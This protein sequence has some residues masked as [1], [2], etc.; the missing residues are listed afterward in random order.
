MAD[1]ALHLLL[2]IGGGYKSIDTEDQPE[3][4]AVNLRM[5][6]AHSEPDP[7][8]PIAAT[9]SVVEEEQSFDRTAYTVSGAWRLEGGV[10]DFD[11]VSYLEDQ[12]INYINDWCNCVSLSAYAQVHYAKLFAV[13]V[14]GK[15]L[16]PDGFGQGSPA[17]LTYKTGSQP[18]GNGSSNVLPP[19]IA[20]VASHRTRQTG[21]G[22]QG[23]QYRPAVDN[24]SVTDGGRLTSGAQAATL[25]SHVAALE[26][27][28][29]TIAAET[30]VRPAVITNT[31]TAA[32]PNLNRYSVI[33]SVRVG[34]VLDTQRRRRNQ[35]VET[36]LETSL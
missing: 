8:G 6:I 31:G 25:A 3:Q 9:Y 14:D 12:G 17:L 16:A 21:R 34:D 30:Y 32:A 27:A 1:T 7:V 28:K 24:D 10:N 11:P 20:I 19:Q 4:W 36:Y 2:T 26:S 35:L 23:R 15:A 18:N 13:G 22:G 29:V 5:V 33:T